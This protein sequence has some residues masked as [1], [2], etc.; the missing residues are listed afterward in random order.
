MKKLS[1]VIPVFNEAASLKE[2]LSRIADVCKN[3]SPHEIICVDDGSFDGSFELLQDLKKI[4]D[5][6]I[7]VH[8]SRNAGQSAALTAGL[9]IAQG[10]IIITMDA[11]LQN[12]PEAIP[13]LLKN[14]DGFDAVVGW[15]KKR[16][17]PFLKRLGSR[18]GNSARRMILRDSFHDN[19][20]TLKAFRQE[21]AADLVKFEHMIFFLPNLIEIAGYRV[22]EVCVPHERRKHGRSKYKPFSLSGISFFLDVLFIKSLK[23]RTLTYTID[24]IIT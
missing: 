24:K 23:K 15:R 3:H 4:Y 22:K 20:C 18:I 10:K 2:L 11:D 6:L 13:I 1:I 17:D 9:K 14:I 12:P 19:A 21:V 5:S 16:N 8:F 7:I